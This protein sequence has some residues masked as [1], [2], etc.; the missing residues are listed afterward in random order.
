MSAFA[1]PSCAAGDLICTLL[2]Q[3][4][5]SARVVNPVSTKPGSGDIRRT[6]MNAA[7]Q[8]MTAAPFTRTVGLQNDVSLIREETECLP[9]SS[10]GRLPEKPGLKC[11]G[12]TH[13]LKNPV[14]FQ[15]KWTTD[16]GMKEGS[17]CFLLKENGRVDRQQTNWK[18]DKIPV[19]HFSMSDIWMS[20]AGPVWVREPSSPRS[21]DDQPVSLSHGLPAESLDELIQ[22]QQITPQLAFQVLLQFDKAI[23]ATLA[24]FCDNVWTFV[25][26]DVEFREVTEMVPMLWSEGGLGPLSPRGLDGQG[27]QGRA[28][29]I[30][31]ARLTFS[32]R[33]CGT[34]LARSH[35]APTGVET[36]CGGEKGWFLMRAHI[37][38][39]AFQLCACMCT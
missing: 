13:G 24:Q 9:S 18:K 10:I 7:S 6:C 25:L 38:K 2:L 17:K 36:G 8:S 19:A 27:F 1:S 29:L 37:H 3:V 35:K 33:P 12:M 34:V 14:S 11:S 30:M 23:N 28:V 20:P 4:S 32:G 31:Q 39:A 21:V 16:L 15:L 5:K 22:S 26:N